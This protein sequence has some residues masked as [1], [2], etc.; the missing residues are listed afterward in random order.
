MKKNEAF[1]CLY[2]KRL[3]KIRKKEKELIS[4]RR[5]NKALLRNNPWIGNLLGLAKKSKAVGEDSSASFESVSSQ[6]S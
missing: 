4:L 2:F 6:D 5:K 3:S 1:A